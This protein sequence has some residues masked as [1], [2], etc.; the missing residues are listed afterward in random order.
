M[1]DLWPMQVA[2]FDALRGMPATY[3]VYDAVQQ[4]AAFPYFV[5]GEFTSLQDD[6]LGEASA[7]ASLN[8][9][10]WSRYAGKKELHE[11]LEFA[12]ARLD[13]QDIGAGVWACFEDFVEMMEDRTSTAASRLYHAVARYRLRANLEES[14]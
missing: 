4:N 2:V 12:R 7:D 11:M 9:H 1:I 3:P 8:V 14:S 5:L 10:A 6:E 13:N